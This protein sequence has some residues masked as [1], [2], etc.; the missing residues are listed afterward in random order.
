MNKKDRKIIGNYIRYE[1]ADG[2]HTYMKCKCERHGARSEM[3]W[4]CWLDI[5]VNGKEQRKN[6]E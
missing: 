5:L 3:C 4:E 1:C 6:G 2:T